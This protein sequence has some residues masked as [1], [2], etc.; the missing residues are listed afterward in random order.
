MCLE[1]VIRRTRLSVMGKRRLL[2]SAILVATSMV[3]SPSFAQDATFLCLNSG[4]EYKIGEFACIPACHGQR[5]L[6]RCDVVAE[7]A[8]WT[9]VSD[10]CPSALLPPAPSDTNMR[11]VA[12]AMTPLPLAIERRLSECRQTESEGQQNG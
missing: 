9:Y 10:V 6:A 7:K 8:S 12:V 2:Q 1:R 4:R 11:P 3:A 5:R